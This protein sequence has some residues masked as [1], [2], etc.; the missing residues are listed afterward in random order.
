MILECSLKIVGISRPHVLIKK[1]LQYEKKTAQV[2][3]PYYENHLN[4]IKIEDISQKQTVNNTYIKYI[5]L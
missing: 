2:T 4:F 5:V 3:R 1:R